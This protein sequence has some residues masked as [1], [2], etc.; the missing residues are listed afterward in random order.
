[1]TCE[2]GYDAPYEDGRMIPDRG[3]EMKVLFCLVLVA[4]AATTRAETPE[5]PAHEAVIMQNYYLEWDH[6]PNEKEPGNF[7]STVRVFNKKTGKLVQTLVTDCLDGVGHEENKGNWA[8]YF[9]AGDFNFDGQEDFSCEEGM[10]NVNYTNTYFLFDARQ[11][12][13]RKGFSLSGHSI[14]FDPADKSVTVEARGGCCSHSKSVYRVIKDKLV[15]KLECSS[16]ISP[17]AANQGISV[18]LTGPD[19]AMDVYFIDDAEAEGASTGNTF[20]GRVLFSSDPARECPLDLKEK[21][22]LVTNEAGEPLRVA[23]TLDVKCGTKLFGTLAVELS[24]ESSSS[25]AVGELVKARYRQLG[26]GKEIPLEW[27]FSCLACG[28]D[29]KKCGAG[30]EQ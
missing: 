4:F 19:S 24:D 20:S 5:R 11:K 18:T 29:G 21:K 16:Y 7:V 9:Q 10:G 23:W 27:G 28:D 14:D 2:T 12:K 13:F 30:V 17:M 6:I 22:A 25:G 8:D 3:G 26:D 1:M 15:P